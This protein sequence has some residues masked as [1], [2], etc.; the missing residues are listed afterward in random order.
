[1][2]HVT[3]GV[4]FRTFS[5]TGCARTKEEPWVSL[6]MC[7]FLKKYIIII[8]VG[9]LCVCVCER[10]RER[11]REKEREREREREREIL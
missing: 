10:E 11:E 5:Q 8:I 6:E 7:V 3:S 2:F 9:I 1:M 4:R